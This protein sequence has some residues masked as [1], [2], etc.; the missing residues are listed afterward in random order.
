MIKAVWISISDP[1][2]FFLNPVRSGSGSELQN[3]VAS[4]SGNRIMFNTAAKQMFCTWMKTL[5][6]CG[7]GETQANQ[8]TCEPT[9][10]AQAQSRKVKEW[11]N[12]YRLNWL[13]TIVVTLQEMRLNV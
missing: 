4:R 10:S 8:M 9:H 7:F 3:P 11:Q 5:M 1:V 2:E 6:R 13:V 12:K